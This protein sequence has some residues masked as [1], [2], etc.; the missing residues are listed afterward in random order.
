MKKTGLLLGL[1]ASC[2]AMG[3]A[4]LGTPT[5]DAGKFEDVLVNMVEK[6]TSAERPALIRV[7]DRSLPAILK[8]FEDEKEA[9][10]WDER[11]T[12]AVKVRIVKDIISDWNI[13]RAKYTS[14]AGVDINTDSSDTDDTSTN[15]DS[16]NTITVGSE[17]EIA[18]Y[19]GNG[20][21]YLGE[22][23]AAYDGFYTI[24]L[25]I[26]PKK[27]IKGLWC[28]MEKTWIAPGQPGPDT[29]VCVEE[30]NNV[31]IDYRYNSWLSDAIG[32]DVYE[33]ASTVNSLQIDEY[34]VDYKNGT[35][36]FAEYNS[37]MFANPSYFDSDI[38]TPS[39]ADAA[40]MDETKYDN[41]I[42]EWATKASDKKQKEYDA[43]A[44]IDEANQE[45]PKKSS[46]SVDGLKQAAEAWA[47]AYNWVETIDYGYVT[48]N[49]WTTVT[50]VFGNIVGRR[51]S[52]VVV[53]T[54]PTTNKCGFHPVVYRQDG[55]GSTYG[56]TYMEGLQPGI[57]YFDCA[58]KGTE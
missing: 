11:A 35:V 16:S 47:N 52:G 45:L 6:R 53:F 58:K 13:V 38:L 57:Y 5:V 31:A 4:F 22:E 25:T 14:S 40:A 10:S 36:V 55:N 23:V 2:F 41:L 7:V 1:V 8:R 9:A 42:E 29:E 18:N 20:R 19:N 43:Q 39:K 54:N 28:N 56:T 32:Y 3:F 17:T 34:L 44:A 21:Y 26:D 46:F 48:S 37:R 49:G 51:V 12:L 50:N 33:N 15:T 30:F 24:E 27:S